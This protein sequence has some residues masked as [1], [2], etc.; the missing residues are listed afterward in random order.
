MMDFEKAHMNCVRKTFPECIYF[1]H[2]F[3]GVTEIIIDEETPIWGNKPSDHLLTKQ[4]YKKRLPMINIPEV[5]FF[6]NK[7]ESNYRE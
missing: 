3:T 2:H 5:H 7:L 4:V 1:M 6:V